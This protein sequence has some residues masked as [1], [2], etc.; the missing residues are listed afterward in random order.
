MPFT[1]NGQNYLKKIF[2]EKDTSTILASILTI[3]AKIL[4]KQEVRR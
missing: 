3:F 1:K 4:D 2:W